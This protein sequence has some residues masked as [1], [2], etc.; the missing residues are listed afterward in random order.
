MAKK[1]KMA[2]NFKEMEELAAKLEGLGGN[3][4]E[5]CDTALRATHDLIT[6]NLSSGIARHVE[7]GETRD[8]LDKAPAVVWDTPLKAHVNI[9]FNL[10]DGGWPSIFLMWGTPKQAPDKSLKNAAF[11]PKVR[12]QVAELQKQAL[13]EAIQK[14]N[15]G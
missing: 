14:M 8:S 1:S 2:F 15:G 9:G 12:R 4:Q 11:G 6:P 10:A 5:A 7:T 13:E 3:L